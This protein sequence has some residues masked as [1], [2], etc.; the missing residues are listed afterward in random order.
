[1]QSHLIAGVSP[2]THDH[3]VLLAFALCKSTSVLNEGTV[4]VRAGVL[5]DAGEVYR[6]V[7]GGTGPLWPTFAINMWDAGFVYRDGAEGLDVMFTPRPVRHPR[8]T[9][10]ARRRGDSDVDPA[11]LPA[12][13][14][15]GS[16][17]PLQGRRG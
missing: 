6:I 13:K 8:H 3:L 5:N 12:G 17:S 9:A 15:S 11:T 10:H 4:Q 14:D 1:M 2:S 7:E 16:G